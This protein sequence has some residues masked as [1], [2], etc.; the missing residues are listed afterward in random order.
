MN[1]KI[2]E[3]AYIIANDIHESMLNV[4]NALEAM[5]YTERELTDADLKDWRNKVLNNIRTQTF[6]QFAEYFAE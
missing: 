4:W 1:Y 6:S 3:L 5:K 2:S